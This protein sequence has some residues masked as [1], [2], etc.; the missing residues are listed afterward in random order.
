MRLNLCSWQ[1]VGAIPSSAKGYFLELWAHR[2]SVFFGRDQ[3]EVTY[4]SPST[5]HFTATLLYF[6]TRKAQEERMEM[7]RSNLLVTWTAL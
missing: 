6:A 4:S 7:G 2:G 3:V 5:T 1:S